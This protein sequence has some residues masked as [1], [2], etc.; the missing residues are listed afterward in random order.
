[1]PPFGK[2]SSERRASKPLPFLSF[3]HAPG[4]SEKARRKPAKAFGAERAE[5]VRDSQ[6]NPAVSST[7]T[8]SREQKQTRV[9]RLP[10]QDEEDE[11]ECHQV[12]KR[13]KSTSSKSKPTPFGD[14]GEEDENDSEAYDVDSESM[15][16]SSV[17]SLGWQTMMNLKQSTFWKE[18]QDDRTDAKQKRT[19]DNTKRREAAVYMKKDRA[20]QYRKSGSDPGRLDV[21]FKQ[22]S[23]SCAMDAHLEFVYFHPPIQI[24][25]QSHI[26]IN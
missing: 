21:L 22:T 4:A 25:S 17:F 3:S 16:S 7:E 24:M 15:Q 19:Y 11:E 14:E 10:F 2:E 12:Q 13:Q 9:S 8:K 6:Q 26:F 23:C 5:A 18:N 1:M 20:G